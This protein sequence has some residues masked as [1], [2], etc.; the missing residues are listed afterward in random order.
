MPRAPQISPHAEGLTDQLY[1]PLADRARASG[2]P[3]RPLHIGDTFREPFEG[4]RV[5]RLRSEAVPM[6]HAYA[7]VQ[8][9][10]ELRAAFSEHLLRTRG[11]RVSPDAL[12]VTAG[13]TSGFAVA[14]HTLLDV[15]DEVLLPAPYWPLVRGVVAGRGAVPVEIPFYDRIGSADFDVEAELERR[16]THKTAA[17]YVNSPSNPTG[18][19]LGR[20][21]LA[22]IVNVAER[23][24]L[25][26][27]ADEAYMDLAFDET[28]PPWFAEPEVARRTVTLYTLSKSH[29]IAGARIGFM[30][31]P[32]RVTRALRGMQMHLAYC[33]PRP[34]QYLAIAALREGYG[35][36]E[37]TRRLYARG[38]EL[39]ARAF[40]APTPRGGTF[41]FADVSHLLP[42]GATSSTPFLEA[43]ADRGVLLTPGTVSGTT[44]ERFVRVC[45]T[46]VPPTELA[47]AL[48]AISDLTQRSVRP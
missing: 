33:A 5:D 42:A 43:C 27:L 21:Q 48:D 19:V 1:S 47:S 7:P 17:I 35:W 6:M 46:S 44:Y 39:T 24:G 28:P 40:G 41:L 2:R 16:I 12:Q 45:F 32:E 22:A 23:H 20:E 31:G 4:A 8:G 29:G 25:W 37:E 11:L 26:I 36:V 34:M 15:G 10:H 30:T 14:I 18:V 38:A 9:E 3:I 13:A